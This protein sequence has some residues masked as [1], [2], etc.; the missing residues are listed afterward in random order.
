MNKAFVLTTKNGVDILEASAFNNSGLVK[1]GFSTR[2]GGISQGAYASMNLATHVADSLTAVQENRRRF[3]NALGIDPTAWV[4]AQQVHGDQVHLATRRDLGRG[5]NDYESSISCRDALITNI[6]GVPLATFYADCVPIFILDPVTPAIGLAH[7]GW[8]GTVAKI[9]QKTIHAMQQAFGTLPQNCLV[10]I[11][12]SIG[13]CCYEVDENVM[14]QVRA[15]FPNWRELAHASQEAGKWMLNLWA[16]NQQQLLECGVRSEHIAVAECC[17]SCNTK[18][19]FSYR[20]ENGQT[21]RM[22]ALL[23]LKSGSERE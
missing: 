13:P 11:A 6:P 2:V 17:T 21:G 12:P 23:M 8:K 4:T 1:H 18:Q 9:P 3:S 5:A 10:A 20:A 16:A 22:G 15:A 19:F 14:L 7:A